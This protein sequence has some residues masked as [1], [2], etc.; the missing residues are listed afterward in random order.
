MSDFLPAVPTI[1]ATFAPT[2]SQSDFLSL[3]ERI[4]SPNWLVPIRD[5]GPGYEILQAYAKIFE[6]CSLAVARL[7]YGNLILSSEGAKKSSVLVT[8]SRP[9]YD[10][11]AFTI[12]QGSIVTTSVGDRR[13]QTAED[14]SFGITSLSVTVIATAVASSYQF[15]VLGPFTAAN[16][17][18][19]PGEIDT[20]VSLDMDPPFADATVTVA[21]ASDA[22]GGQPPSLDGL[23]ED[24]GVKRSSGENDDQYRVR[25]R[26][27]PDTI[28]PDAI[29]RSVIAYLAKFVQDT[30][31][32]F[33]E[34]SDLGSY[35]DVDFCDSGAIVLD[36]IEFRAMFIIRL[37]LWNGFSEFGC[38][39]DDPGEVS[40]DFVTGA[41]IIDGHRSTPAYDIPNIHI[42]GVNQ[43]A[44]DGYDLGAVALYEKL[45][46]T[47]QKIKAAGVTALVEIEV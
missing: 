39:Y 44:Y 1:P 18:I 35:A 40:D 41:P 45:Y 3:F 12:R 27:L 47:L 7:L 19:V 10:A 28:S 24:R 4:T 37:P 17:E 20:I 46:D 8:F 15:N 23:G 36:E 16:G 29:E 43:C 42:D 14:V 25:V 22:T 21:Q 31:N 38:A 2:L 5:I 11:G 33:I 9:T 30:S 32:E 6:R 34:A 13:F 26:T